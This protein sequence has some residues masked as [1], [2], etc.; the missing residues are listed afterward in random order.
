M[1]LKDNFKVPFQPEPIK[2]DELGRGRLFTLRGPRQVGKTRFLKYLGTQA[3]SA[4]PIYESL[5]IVRTDREL[6]ALIGRLIREH[7]SKLILLDE[8]SSVPRWQKAIKYLADK[9]DLAG[10][11]FVLSGSSATDIKRGAERLPGRRGPE[12]EGGWDRVLLPLNFYQ[13]VEHSAVF[14]EAELTTI[15]S[16]TETPEIVPEVLHQKLQK[17]FSDFVKI[18]GFPLSILAWQYGELM[19]FRTMM[20]TIRSDFEKRKKSRVILDQVLTRM[21]LTTGTAVT[22]EAFAKTITATKVIVRQ[23]LDE[24]CENYLLLDVECID[25]ARNHAAPRKPRKLYWVDPLVSAAIMEDGIGN[26]VAEPNGVE[27]IVAF[28]LARKYETNLWE[29]LNQLRRVYVWRDS[30]GHEV[31]FILWLKEKKAI[32][33]KWQNQVSEWDATVVNKTFGGG[34]LLC[35]DQFARFGKT[36]VVPVSWFLFC[37]NLRE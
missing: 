34:T 7:R 11:D 6:V 33:V 26:R 2:R 1:K 18:G 5:D 36:D 19:P 35:K 3:A 21:N 30:R 12:V 16:N 4:N 10:I 28:E 20:A 8:I 15:K 23:Y 14:T 29:G 25:L 17:A 31:D 13:F 24:L 27:S 37:L 9:G 32:E 22:W